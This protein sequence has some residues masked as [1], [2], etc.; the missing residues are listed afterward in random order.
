MRRD[1]LKLPLYRPRGAYIFEGGFDL[2]G[3]EFFEYGEG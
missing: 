2:I 1:I 3:H